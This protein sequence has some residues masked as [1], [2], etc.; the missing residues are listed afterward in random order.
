[1]TELGFQLPDGA[2]ELRSTSENADP[3]TDTLARMAS[4]WRAVRST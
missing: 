4:H 1:M 2:S 3:H